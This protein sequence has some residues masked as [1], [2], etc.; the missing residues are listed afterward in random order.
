MAYERVPIAALF[1]GKK[2]V[3]WFSFED[4]PVIESD[5]AES[6]ET[7]IENTSELVF[8]KLMAAVDAQR[9]FTLA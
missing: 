5:G 7:Q 2:L 1:D 9:A 3:S 6:Q 4:P 8:M